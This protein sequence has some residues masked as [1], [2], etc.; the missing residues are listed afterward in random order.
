MGRGLGIK[1]P[2]SLTIANI[3]SSFHEQSLTIP[4]LP[5]GWLLGITKPMGQ[6]T[7]AEHYARLFLAQQGGI[8][9]PPSMKGTGC[10]GLQRSSSRGFP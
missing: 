3:E 4:S 1:G 5:A 8:R 2:K 9:V 10:S 6:D 7:R